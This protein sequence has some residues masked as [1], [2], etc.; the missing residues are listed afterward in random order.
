[1]NFSLPPR[2]YSDQHYSGRNSRR[3][4]TW[5]LGSGYH[6]SD[7][8]RFV[9]ANYRFVVLPK[10]DYSQH[11]VDANAYLEWDSVIQ[12][13]ASAQS[14]HSSCPICLSTPV[15][16]RMAKCGHIF[17]LPC[18]IRY[19]HSTDDTNKPLP[20]KKARWKKCPICWDSVFLNEARPVRWLKT[21]EIPPQA[22]EDVIL[23]LMVR[24]PGNTLALPRDSF[25][26]NWRVQDVP[27]HFAPNVMD[28]ARVMKGTEEYMNSQLDGEIDD[29]IR[30]EHEDDI[31]FGEGTE[32]TRKAIGSIKETK[33]KMKGIGDLSSPLC[34]PPEM[35]NKRD[36]I[37]FTK[38]DEYGP[39]MY[40][41]QNTAQSGQS[42]PSGVP[43]AHS[44]NRSNIS[45]NIWI[46]RLPISAP[47]L[48]A[49]DS[50]KH[51]L[52]STNSQSS[53]HER[54]SIH[55]DDSNSIDSPYY[56]YQALTHYYLSPLDIRILKVA[57]GSFASFPTTILPRVERVSTDHIV[58]DELRKRAK[59][60]GHLPYGCEVGF[61]ECD[62]TD[63]V[64]L[65]VLEQ[66]KPDLDRRRQKNRDKENRE[67]KERLRAEK[68]ED[69][70]RWASVARRKRPSTAEKNPDSMLSKGV[71]IQL[72][73]EP[74]NL[75]SSP[76][77][78]AKTKNS[79]GSVF[80]SLASP[81]TS[82]ATGRTVWG[83]AAILSSSPPDQFEQLSDFVE[84]ADDGWLNDYDNCFSIEENIANEI[85]ALSMAENTQAKDSSRQTSGAS[86]K[87]KKTKK[88][89]L[90]S[91]N[92]RR[93][94]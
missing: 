37:N 20:E 65:D 49:T 61:L 32:W 23:R 25:G 88:I 43:A 13:L 21:Q 68:T 80:A 55:P 62:L 92:A 9:H 6:A 69:E 31:M 44:A 34:K 5:G 18:L 2:P 91:T 24:Q 59:Y 72:S 3:N 90:M 85:K 89:T 52:P 14:Q 73:V 35:A 8:A 87:R 53:L 33:G 50:G 86:G 38:V 4:P 17:C 11:A 56:F 79:T 67:E 36:P 75:S 64:P 29:L 66:F 77:W 46:S 63:I 1:M 42:T 51:V 30:Q 47:D 45:G 12:V 81:S 83:T 94:A 84:D 76:P 16:P 93:G 39:E 22:G 19:M 40:Y 7:K 82:P 60:L 27:W 10:D 26:V 74:T 41:I 58:D 28:Y 54:K 78:P 15:A 57:F 70:Q 71:D 48:L